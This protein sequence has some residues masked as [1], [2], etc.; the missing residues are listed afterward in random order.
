MVVVVTS[1]S[2]GQTGGAAFEH[3]DRGPRRDGKR[4]GDGE[5]HRRRGADRNRPHVR[6][7]QPTD[8]RH[9][10]NRRNHRQSGEDRRIANFVDGFERELVN[11]F[12]VGTRQPDVAHDIFDDDD[13]VIHQDSD[14]EDQREERDAVQRV[15]VEVKNEE[16]ER[17]RRGDREEDDERLPPA[18]E[19]QNQNRHAKDRDAHVQ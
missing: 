14:R 10:K 9:R 1:G 19:K 11:R 7:H 4:D 12:L 17:E 8:E 6:A 16:R 5:Q 2:A 13:C 18:K 15:A 3:T